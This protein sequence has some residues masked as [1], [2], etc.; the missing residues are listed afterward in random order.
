MSSDAEQSPM[1]ESRNTYGPGWPV[2]IAGRM[3]K[4]EQNGRKKRGATLDN[5][6]KLL[7]QVGC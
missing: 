5:F 4:Q 6:S 7:Q 2:F 1:V 3:R